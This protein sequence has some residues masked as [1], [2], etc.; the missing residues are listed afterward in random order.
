M[1]SSTGTRSRSR[2]RSGAPSGAGSRP[3]V[4]TQ[5]S[6]PV[7]RAAVP[8]AVGPVTPH[9][10]SRS[11]RFG[12][13][14]LQQLIL[15]ESAAALLLAAWVV[16]TMALVPAGVVAVALVLLAVVRRRGRSLPEWLGTAWALRAR[17]KRASNAVVPPG[18]LPGLAPAV[19]CDPTLRTYSHGDRDQ[20]PIGMIGDGGFLTVVL[21]VES[22]ATALRAERGQRPLPLGLVRDALEVDDIRLE[23]AQILLHTQPAPALRLPQ[24]SVAVTNYA[25]LH[26]QTASPA[27]RITWIALKLNPEL[28]PEAVAARG[29]GLEGAQKC[30]A[31]T[32]LHLASRLT[33]AGLNTTVLTEEELADAV[34]TSACANPLVTAQAGRTETPQRRTEESARSWR[35]D[36]RRHTTYWV[37]RWPRIDAGSGTG[38]LPQLVALLTAVP[39]LATTF[40]LTIAP[41]G[42][43]ES[44]ISGH[45]RVTGRSEAELATARQALERSAREAKAQ[46][47]PLDHEQLPGMLATL[48]FGGAR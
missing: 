28:C 8:A 29:G 14:R 40:S 34:A 39:A 32:A 20:R 37:R 18:T 4:R 30:A 21:Q 31:R 33:G 19:E 17:L 10:K 43:Q 26:A 46:I 24:Q 13:F 16:D 6:P 42:A 5:P 11:G 47:V 25:P 7:R 41:V 45:L 35:C 23:S 3:G 22:D 2:E 38:G 9:L 36:N 48:P 27:V 15:I 1:V 44:G 12:S